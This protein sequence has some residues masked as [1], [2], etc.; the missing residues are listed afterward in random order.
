MQKSVKCLDCNYEIE[1]P[2]DSEVGD[3]F[4]CNEC[5]VEVEVISV[6][7]LE[8]DYLLVEK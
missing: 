6:D 7:P 8:I 5:G 3:V 1:V 4:L 2:E